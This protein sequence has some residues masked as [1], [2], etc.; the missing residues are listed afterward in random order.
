MNYQRIRSISLSE[1][2][3]AEILQANDLPIDDLKT[4]PI[5]FYGIFENDKMK[6]IGDFE[7]Y[8]KC[9]ILRSI[10]VPK[11]FRGMGYGKEVVSFVEKT[12]KEKQINTLYLLTTT[13]Y[14]YF[15]KYGYQTITLDTCPPDILSSAEFSKLCPSSARCYSK[16]F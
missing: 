12:A 1:Y 9:A 8:G 16:N 13:A 3:I 15:Q 5:Q 10:A 2:P 6:G 11:E 14:Q 7:T 4:A